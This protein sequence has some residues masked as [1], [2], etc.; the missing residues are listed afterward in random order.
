MIKISASQIKTYRACPTKWSY[1]KLSGLKSPKGSGKGAAFGSMV[2][3]HLER[4]GLKEMLPPSDEPA[5]KV[6]L[7]VIAGGHVPIGVDGVYY[8]GMDPVGRMAP[9]CRNSLPRPGMFFLSS[10]REDV[11]LVGYIDQLDVRDPTVPVVVDYKTTSNLKYALT[12]DELM[13]DPQ[14]VLYA[15]Y[16]FATHPAQ[17]VIVRFVY[18]HVKNR[19][20]PGKVVLREITYTPESILPYTAGLVSDVSAMADAHATRPDMPK[21]TERCYDY[22]GCPWMSVCKPIRGEPLPDG[23]TIR[24]RRK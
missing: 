12:T 5:G 22:G 19:T 7:R 15:L 14:A 23:G 9:L 6:A 17:K 3:T 13:S 4:Y 1:D 21:N 8:E 10:G 16:A 11:T 24:I 20:E 18:V 2:H